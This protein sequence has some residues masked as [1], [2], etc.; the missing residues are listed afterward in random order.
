M[1]RDNV[2]FEVAL[3]AVSVRNV[4]FDGRPHIVVPAVLI[5]VGVHNGSAGA[6]MYPSEVIA[7][8]VSRW[9]NQPI[10]LDHP[11][12]MVNSPEVINNVGLGTVWNVKFEDGS[13]KGELWFDEDKVKRIAPDILNKIRNREMFELST[14]LGFSGKRESG[15]FNNERYEAVLSDMW[16]DHLAVLLNEQGA[17]SLKDGCGA[18]RNNKGDDPKTEDNMSDKKPCERITA[19]IKNSGGLLTEE[20]HR[21]WLEGMSS[22]Q[23]D[24]LAPKPVVNAA[25][26]VD[27][28][29]INKAV[30]ARLAEMQAKN[31]ADKPEPMTVDQ[32][33]AAAPPEIKELVQNA[34]NQKAEIISSLVANEKCLYGEDML[35]NMSMDALN[36]LSVMI[37]EPKKT[38]NYVFAAGGAAKNSDAPK[39]MGGS[40]MDRVYGTDKKEGE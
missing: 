13:L 19:L 2:N 15:V 29:V 20:K 14:G 7:K 3:N 28:D 35:K 26:K 18:L 31:K 12:S 36:Q 6:L 9:N 39:P 33:M 27:E 17:C 10:T 11:Q 37:A 8:S 16:P 4:M 25:P 21:D 1:D 32:F 38:P 40:G 5:T 23:L 30:E 24:L 34:A 22:D